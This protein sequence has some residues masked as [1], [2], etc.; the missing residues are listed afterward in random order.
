MGQE[1][2]FRTVGLVFALALG[3]C[4]STQTNGTGGGSTG[5]VSISQVVGPA[6][7]TVS[8][9]DGTSVEIPAGALS[10]NVTV[11]LIQAPN[12]TAPAE[13]VWVGIPYVFRPEGTQF[14]K[15][16]TVT[17]AFSVNSIPAYETA[18]QVV[19]E[20]A[21]LDSTSYTSLGGT[22]SDAS[23][24]SALT[25]HF[26][27]FGPAA[28]VSSDASSGTT[29]GSL[30]DG[31]EE[32]STGTTSGGTGMGAASSGTGSGTTTGAVG[33][34]STG[35]WTWTLPN[36]GGCVG[37]GGC[38]VVSVIN[39][40]DDVGE[41][42]GLCYYPFI[43]LTEVGASIANGNETIPDQTS[44]NFGYGIWMVGLTMPACPSAAGGEI[45]VEA[46]VQLYPTPGGLCSNSPYEATGTIDFEPFDAGFAGT[47]QVSLF[48]G[49]QGSFS[50]GQDPSLCDLPAAVDAG[51]V[52]EDAGAT[53]CESSNTC[54]SD[55]G[56][57]TGTGDFSI[58]D[59]GS[60]GEN[61][62][63]GPLVGL[64]AV[65]TLTNSF[66]DLP[67]IQVNFGGGEW[68]IWADLSCCPA[69]AGTLTA[70]VSLYS[71]ICQTV[72][73][74]AVLFDVPGTVIFTETDGGLEGWITVDT[75]AGLSS[76]ASFTIPAP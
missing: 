32:T 63:A 72:G 22:L 16:A 31:G 35:A 76:S 26:S 34:A 15:A 62:C 70:T 56:S 28:G 66:Q 73:E 57:L 50:F 23:H 59:P 67:E 61:W 74:I 4:Q 53:S 11:T 24:I 48:G 41:G 6:G 45:P 29:G 33:G 39:G 5:G 9:P 7:G 69:G 51:T 21:P 18:S 13:S 68:A 38:A 44:F 40:P 64:P 17:L 60:F 42:A 10:S 19:V 27:T 20:T 47:F 46:Y 71:S 65:A 30:S 1:H 14:A 25:T 55:A 37:A 8:A 36:D 54:L 49:M 52:P 43:P 3:A 2:R 58:S 75:D 12:A